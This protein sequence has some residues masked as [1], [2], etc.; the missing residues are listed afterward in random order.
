MYV[1]Y[2]GKESHSKTNVQ[3]PKRAINTINTTQEKIQTQTAR[4]IGK[5]ARVQR[6]ECPPACSCRKHHALVACST[7]LHLPSL[8]RDCGIH[9]LQIRQMAT[10]SVADLP[11]EAYRNTE[12][13]VNICTC[14][15]PK[16][17]CCYIRK[18]T[19]R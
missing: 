8:E 6:T 13:K 7:S 14:A 9:R 11:R 5:G 19:Y 2:E 10:G 17:I 18:R 4:Q 1:L 16:K 12:G 15:F 3:H